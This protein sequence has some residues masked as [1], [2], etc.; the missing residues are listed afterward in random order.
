MTHS[1]P[2]GSPFALGLALPYYMSQGL[3]TVGTQLK[4]RGQW[5]VFL[6]TRGPSIGSLVLHWDLQA[7]AE[8]RVK[9][10]QSVYLFLYLPLFLCLCLSCT[11][12]S[13]SPVLPGMEQ[14][15]GLTGSQSPKSLV[16][17]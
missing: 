16:M 5:E 14:L 2:L 8:H 4:G 10:C 3:R 12:T 9:S 7:R 1:E 13:C 11:H 15:G 6:W 17:S